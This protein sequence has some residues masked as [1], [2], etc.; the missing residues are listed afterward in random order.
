[1]SNF[2]EIND[3][4]D[5]IRARGALLSARGQAFSARTSEL[6]GRINGIEAGAPW[7]SDKYGKEFLE[8]EHGGYHSTKHTDV[9]FNEYVKTSA[10]GVGPKLTKTGDAI[11]GAMTGYQFADIDNQGDIANVQQ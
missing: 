2:V 4:P 5:E 11:E 7:G 9:P 3:D 6:V 8:N 10:S 1:M